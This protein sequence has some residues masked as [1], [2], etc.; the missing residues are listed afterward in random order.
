MNNG[1]LHDDTHA[2]HQTNGGAATED[3]SATRASAAYLG[4]AATRSW[5]EAERS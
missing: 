4:R 3:T 1:V 5:A 2:L